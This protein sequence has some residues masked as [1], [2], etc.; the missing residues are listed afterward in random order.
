MCGD[1]AVSLVW[2]SYPGYREPDVF[3]IAECRAC[4]TRFAMP[5]HG[6]TSALYEAIYRQA[7]RIPGY[8]R[9]ARYAVDVERS[10]DPLGYLANREPAYWGIC[11]TLARETGDRLKVLEVGSGLGYLTSALRHAGHE[12]TGL[13][14]SAEAVSRARQRFGPY[15]EDMSIESFA[16]SQPGQVDVVVATEVVEHL[17]APLPF[18]ESCLRAARPGGAVVVTTPNKDCYA[19]HVTWA[20]DSPPVHLLWLTQDSLAA[21]AIRL[22]AT[23][24]FVDLGGFPGSSSWRLRTPRAGSVKPPIL[25]RDG[26]P[27]RKPEPAQ[28]LARS[29][30]SLRKAASLRVAQLTGR[31]QAGQV[32][33]SPTL[34][35]V[36]RRSPS[37]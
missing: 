24:E 11:K 7:D 12:A 8:E 6:D 25:D 4:R 28:G 33:P 22:G 16:S 26:R 5:L 37:T 30:K 31:T 9:Y 20:V 15:F 29:L 18:L 23:V 36:F 34:C 1:T 27:R 35:A 13:D 21:A 10:L 32:G 17:P 3:D 19:P 14:I 2:K